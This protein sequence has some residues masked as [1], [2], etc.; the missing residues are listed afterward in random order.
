[1]REE[2]GDRQVKREDRRRHK[3]DRCSVPKKHLLSETSVRAEARLKTTGYRETN[4]SEADVFSKFL[5]SFQSHFLSIQSAL[6][7]SE[8]ELEIF[9]KPKERDLLLD[10]ISKGVSTN[11]L[12]YELHLQVDLRSSWSHW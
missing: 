6:V 2:R 9:W 8:R 5:Q 11:D 7:S 3:I 10:P 12:R 4:L 1:M